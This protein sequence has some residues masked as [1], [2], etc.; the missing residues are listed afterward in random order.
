MA[1]TTT[2][3]DSTVLLEALVGNDFGFV[4][5]SSDSGLLEVECCFESSGLSVDL[6]LTLYRVASEIVSEQVT[7][8]LGS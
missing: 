6:T 3:F 8:I 7:S 4:S 2:S 1:I 5:G